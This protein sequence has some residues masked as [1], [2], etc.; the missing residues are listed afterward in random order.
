[1]KLIKREL[2]L[3]S[4]RNTLWV[5]L[6]MV[7][8]CAYF[9][10]LD[11]MPA[12]PW[13]QFGEYINISPSADEAE[14]EILRNL[15][16]KTVVVQATRTSLAHFIICLFLA[17]AS[18]GK[19]IHA[20]Y[21]SGMRINGMKTWQMFW[22]SFGMCFGVCLV[23]FLL[24]NGISLWRVR[25]LWWGRFDSSDMVFLL[26]PYFVL[27]LSLICNLAMIFFCF[28][29]FG[30]YARVIPYIV[31]FCMNVCRG[32]FSKWYIGRIVYGVD[33]PPDTQ[34]MRAYYF[35]D[36]EELQLGLNNGFTP[37]FDDPW[38][39]K[40][41]GETVIISEIVEGVIFLLAAWLIF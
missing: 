8:I 30:R 7:V 39:R 31:F 1:M 3:W 21:F 11:Y 6:G 12:A 16:A 41:W 4:K 24:G 37:I 5:I 33:G 17:G 28:T 9:G 32:E 38:N 10:Y 19:D 20:D 34:G 18:F 13:H 14:K 23:L 26:R 35:W 22:V 36:V 40:V 15:L 27:I 2:L 25:E 29:V